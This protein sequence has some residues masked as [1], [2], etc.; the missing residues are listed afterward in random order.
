M[1]HRNAPLTPAGRQKMVDLVLLDGWSQRRV[2]ERF[3]VS[4]AT[5]NRWV[6]R[7][8][9]GE[10]LTD[11]PSRPRTCPHQLPTRMQ[12]RII[13]LRSTRQWGPHRIGYHLGIARSTVGRVLARYNMPKLACIDQA[14]GLPVRKQPPVRYE[15]SAPGELIHLDI[16]KLGRIPDGGGWRVHGRGSEQ[17]RRAGRARNRATR[18]GA[19]AGRGYSYLHHAVDDYSRMVY[20]EI[21]PDEKKDTAAGFMKRA[22]AFFS[23]QGI[24]VKRVMTDNGACYRSTAFDAALG[25][26]I[27]HLYTKPYRPQTNGKVERFNRTLM[28][29]WA[30]LRPYTSERA[31]QQTYAAFIHDYNYHRAHTAIGGLTP[32]QRVHNVTGKYI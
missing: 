18:A 6:T 23:T 3:Q 13:K 29:E 20:S 27:K 15:H 14:T 25:G 19:P 12:R 22:C 28:Q 24:A 8:R 11:R 5:V 21:L 1:T 32:A 16:K 30:Y 31:R 4:A 10:D 2:A 26:V 9:N 17:D 7:A